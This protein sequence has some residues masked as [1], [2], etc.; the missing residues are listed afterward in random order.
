MRG[1]KV[2]SL[3]G[4][5]MGAGHP[6]DQMIRRLVLAAPHVTSGEERQAG[7]WVLYRL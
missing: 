5:G 1:L 7:G 4:F 3:D 2:E 6:K